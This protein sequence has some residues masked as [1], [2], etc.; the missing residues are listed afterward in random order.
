MS[1]TQLFQA[2][3]EILALAP[4]SVAERLDRAAADQTI[5]WTVRRHGGVTRCAAALAYEF[6]E[7]PELVRGKVNWARQVV[8]ALYPA[9][10]PWAA[11]AE[12]ARCRRGTRSAQ[13]ASR[14]WDRRE[15]AVSAA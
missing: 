10:A 12:Q 5:R 7:H 6:G 2:R 1:E 3:V 4:V 15:P 9:R 13:P 11:L 14:D 8:A